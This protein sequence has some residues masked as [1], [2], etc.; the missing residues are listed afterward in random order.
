VLAQAARTLSPHLVGQAVIERGHVAEQLLARAALM[1]ADLIVLGS[2]GQTQA[3]GFLQGSVADQVLSQAHCAVLVAKAA[4]KP[5]VVAEPWLAMPRTA[6][7][8]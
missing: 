3:V 2:R 5:R 1:N 8:L 4:L 6:V 7:A